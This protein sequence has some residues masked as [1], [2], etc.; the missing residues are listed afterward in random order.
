MR[1]QEGKVESIEAPSL[2][3][4]GFSRA[5]DSEF[6]LLSEVKVC[7]KAQLCLFWDS[8]LKFCVAL[9]DKLDPFVE[10]FADVEDVVGGD[11]LFIA[12]MQFSAHNLL[13]NVAELHYS[14]YLFV[15][16]FL[17]GLNYFKAIIER[18]VQSS[19]LSAQRFQLYNDC[20]FVKAALASQC[21]A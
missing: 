14:A 13:E 18:S 6:G 3:F 19:R 4:C 10:H 11:L 21:K 7:G 8:F 20:F 12:E 17:H 2:I 16:S 9:F 1:F 15:D 5:E